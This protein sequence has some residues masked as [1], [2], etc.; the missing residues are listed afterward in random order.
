MTQSPEGLTAR[1]LDAAQAAGADAADATVIQGTS[2]SIDVRAGVLEQAARAEGIDLGLRVFLGLRTANV[3]PSDT[4]DSTL[5][6]L[7]VRAVA[8]AREVHK[9]H[10][11]GPASPTQLASDLA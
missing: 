6:E 11:A 9:E 5:D 10:K 7:T 2:L 1:L 4:R 8:M 3:Q